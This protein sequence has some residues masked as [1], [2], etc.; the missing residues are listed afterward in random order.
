M[1]TYPAEATRFDDAAVRAA[2]ERVGLGH[3]VPSLDQEDRW[4]RQLALDEQQRL[5]F[6]RL[7][8]HAPRWIFLDDGIGALG[9]EYRQLVFSI[10]ERDLAHAAVIRFGRDRAPDGMWHRTLHVIVV[11]T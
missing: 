4:D 9:E 7:V 3:L 1:V 11:G 2:L 5:A 6:A 10:L 8:L